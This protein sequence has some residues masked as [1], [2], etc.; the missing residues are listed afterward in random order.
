MHDSYYPWIYIIN[1]LFLLPFIRLNKTNIF[2][3]SIIIIITGVNG[4]L[5]ELSLLA[6]TPGVN[7]GL[8]RRRD[9]PAPG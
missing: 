5:C 1:D 8:P 3:A 7:R 9:Y 6:Q 2:I 4:V